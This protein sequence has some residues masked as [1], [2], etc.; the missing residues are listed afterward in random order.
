[1]ACRLWAA[2][3]FIELRFKTRCSEHGVALIF[4]LSGFPKKNKQE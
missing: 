4:L 1:M 3:Y 2:R